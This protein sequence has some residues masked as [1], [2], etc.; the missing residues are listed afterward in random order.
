MKLNYILTKR[1]ILLLFVILLSSSVLAEKILFIGDSHSQGT[2]GIEINKLLR[3]GNTVRHYAMCGASPF[4]WFNEQ[5]NS[6]GSLYIDETGKTSTLSKTPI[7]TNLISDFQPN[8]ILITMGGNM[9]DTSSSSRIS[10]VKKLVEAITSKNIKCYWIGPPQVPDKSAREQL[11]QDIKTGLSDKCT[12]IDSRPYAELTTSDGLHFPSGSPRAKNWA[13]SVYNIITLGS[14]MDIVNKGIAS[15]TKQPSTPS[16]QTL[17]PTPQPS[18]TAKMSQPLC[19][20]AQQCKEIDE[21]WASRISA[22][23]N[24]ELSNKVY[25]VPGGWV[26]FEQLYAVPKPPQATADTYVS[27]TNTKSSSCG[28]ASYGSPEMRALLDTIGSVEASNYNKMYCGG[29]FSDYSKHPF[30]TSAMPTAITCGSYTSTAAGRYQFL[31]G[32]YTSLKQKGNFND[33]SPSEQDKSAIYLITT[34]RGVS[35][36]ELKTA[37]NTKNFISIW[38]KLSKEWAS[39]PYSKS[40]CTATNCGNG[41]SYYGQSAN[42]DQTLKDRFFQC[43]EIQK[44]K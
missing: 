24:T 8:T 9:K 33:F 32:T 16:S 10:Q 15:A 28:V 37:I 13:Q 7:I 25:A 42:T 43:Y 41:K 22:Y 29:T 2:Y 21:A 14:S 19:L 35:E 5:A 39:L 1:I 20:N 44:K 27:S 30:G 12:L 40:D 6:C 34:S 11:Y 31:S 17:S 36:E 26:P 3:Q 4:W 23:V 18:P 38:D